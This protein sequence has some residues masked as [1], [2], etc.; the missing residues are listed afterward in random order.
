MKASLSGQKHGADLINRGEG[1][2][3]VKFKRERT[4]L[5][6][7]VSHRGLLVNS[8]LRRIKVSTLPTL[9]DILVNCPTNPPRS[10]APT[11]ISPNF[12]SHPLPLKS[13]PVLCIPFKPHPPPHQAFHSNPAHPSI[14][15]YLSYTTA[16]TKLDTRQKFNKLSRHDGVQEPCLEHS[17][18][19]LPQDHCPRCSLHLPPIFPTCYLH[20]I[21]SPPFEWMAL[22]CPLVS[23]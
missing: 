7:P 10:L 8:Q 1:I 19:F 9:G 2:R 15:I 16:R 6:C 21:L 5:R 18:D 23:S 13:H 12:A 22:S 20:A 3:G 17:N 14:R 4:K 11:L